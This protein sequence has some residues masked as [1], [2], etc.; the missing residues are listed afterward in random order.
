MTGGARLPGSSSTT[1]FKLTVAITTASYVNRSWSRTCVLQIPINL[2]QP[3]CLHSMV[4]NS[5]GLGMGE[6]WLALA[7]TT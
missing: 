4:I 7:E 5:S 1:I 2:K 3:I 6:V